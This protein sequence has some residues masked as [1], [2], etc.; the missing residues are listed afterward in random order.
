MKQ[1]PTLS[2]SLSLISLSRHHQLETR[3]IGVLLGLA[4]NTRARPRPHEAIDHAF[5]GQIQLSPNSTLKHILSFGMQRITAGIHHGVSNSTSLG[6][7]V[8]RP[9]A[10]LFW[11]NLAMFVP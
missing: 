6:A 8:F 2:F 1:F 3:L 5:T 11:Q 10:K 4:P 9:G 7:T